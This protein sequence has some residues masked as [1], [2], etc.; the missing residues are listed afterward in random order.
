MRDDNC[1]PENYPDGVTL[2]RNIPYNRFIEVLKKSY[3]E[4]N[5]FEDKV[6]KNQTFYNRNFWNGGEGADGEDLSPNELMKE[7]INQHLI[8]IMPKLKGK[9]FSEPSLASTTKRQNDEISYYGN[10][11]LIIKI[12]K[13]HVEKYLAVDVAKKGVRYN[14]EEVTL[15]PNQKF[16]IVSAELVNEDQILRVE[17]ESF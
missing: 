11:K 6:N 14:E 9:K 17:L 5:K 4:F 12:K 2:Y 13:E 7:K 15:P 1:L 3:S 8:P 10:V 16:L